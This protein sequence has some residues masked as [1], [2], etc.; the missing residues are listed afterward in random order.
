M[1]AFKWEIFFDAPESGMTAARSQQFVR[2]NSCVV[3]STGNLRLFAIILFN[4]FYEIQYV[5]H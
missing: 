2:Q 4:H 1:S 3:S 5:L